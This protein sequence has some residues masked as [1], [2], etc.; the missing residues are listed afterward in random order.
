MASTHLPFRSDLQERFE[1]AVDAV[2]SGDAASLSQLLEENPELVR[3]RSTLVT[4][5]D[6]PQHR[7]TLLHYIAANGVE[8]YRQKSPKNAVEIARILLEAGAD[9]N[10]LASMYGGECTIM[11]MLVSSTP[12]HDAGVQVPLV[13]V[14]VDYGAVVEPSGQGAWTSPLLTA[15]VFG[16]PDAAAALLERGARADTLPTA[17]GLGRLDDVRR[18]LPGSSADDRHRA[19]ALSAQMGHTGVV[20]LLLDAG[21]DP[22]R[23]NPKGTH[24][25]TTP[26]HQAIARGH[27]DVVKLL[28]ERGASLD[29]KDTIHDGTPLGWARYLGKKDIEQFLNA[30]SP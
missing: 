14:L 20:R 11:S 3:A 4:D 24:A 6:P 15:I 13:H 19:L 5:G 27:L 22:N 1:A 10:A 28:V 2:I 29:I 17:A 25:H 12:P 30:L 7:A 16:F 21:E 9:P 23:F 26:I 8:G 18:M